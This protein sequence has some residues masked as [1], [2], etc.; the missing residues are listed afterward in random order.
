MMRF[1][2]LCAES[3][4]SFRSR[5][6]ARYTRPGHEIEYAAGAIAQVLRI[7]AGRYIEGV[8]SIPRER[9]A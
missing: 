9:A 1:A 8:S 2:S 6:R 5:K 7:S 3:R 4:V